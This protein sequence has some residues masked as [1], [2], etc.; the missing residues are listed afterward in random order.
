[1]SDARKLNARQL[2]FITRYL[3]TDN[4]TQSY[5][6]A[7]DDDGKM[8]EETA[9]ACA[10]RMLTDAKVAAELAQRRAKLAERTDLTL[11]SHLAELQRLRDFALWSGQMS[12]AV[13]AETKRGEACGLYVKRTE[14]VSRL[15]PAER[16]ERVVAI[17]KRRG[18]KLEKTG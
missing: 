4:G 2:R 5:L 15:T 17:L 11:E 3:V 8:T 18:I 1:M 9:A 7:Y 6:D 12:A 16:E 13:T 10:S 14:D